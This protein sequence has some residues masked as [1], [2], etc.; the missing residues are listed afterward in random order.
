MEYRILIVLLIMLTC[1]WGLPGCGE[2]KPEVVQEEMLSPPVEKIEDEEVV[3]EQDGESDSEEAAGH[4]APSGNTPPAI[5]S[6]EIMPFPAYT[7]TD[8]RVKV[9]GED[10]DG[11]WIDYAYQWMIVKRGA[12]IE[13][14]QELIEQ[15]G[16]ALSHKLFERDDAVAVKVTPSDWYSEGETYSTKFVVIVNAPPKIVSTPP[17]AA[18][19]QYRYQVK[20]EDADGDKIRYSLGEGAPDGMKIDAQ[21]GLLTWTLSPGNAGAYEVLVQA[22][23]G[24]GGSSFQR[25]SLSMNVEQSPERNE[26]QESEEPEDIEEPE[27]TEGLQDQGEAEKAQEPEKTDA[28]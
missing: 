26:L 17:G 15:T 10:A 13:D 5:T 20:A 14:A 21:T 18:V 9:E 3:N 27:G 2:D 23:D 11:D 8:L 24:N 12:T 22:H 19:D 25:F 4:E 7:N 28:W 6:A 16:P 1:F